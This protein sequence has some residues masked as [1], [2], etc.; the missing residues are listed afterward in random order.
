MLFMRGVVSAPFLSH[1]RCVKD[2]FLVASGNTSGSSL[3]TDPNFRDFLQLQ[4]GRDEKSAPFLRP[5]GLGSLMRLLQNGSKRLFR[6]SE[7]L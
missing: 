3:R 6:K 7:A 1:H 2:L 5:F 4:T